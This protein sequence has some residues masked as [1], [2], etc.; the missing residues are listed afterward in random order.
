VGIPPCSTWLLRLF[1]AYCDR[2]AARHF[3]SIR[4]SLSG[5]LPGP[6]DLPWVFYSNHPSWWDPVMAILFRSLMFPQRRLFA[7]MD[8]AALEKYKFF[9]KLG[10]FGVDQNKLSGAAAFLRT[11][12]A[13][14]Q[15]HD[16]MLWLTPQGR[17]ADPRER[18][19]AFRGGL[20]GL[21]ARVEETLFVPLA[22]EYVFWE[23]RHPEILVRFGRATR[24]GSI[25]HSAIEWNEILAEAL[26]QS[27]DQLA[28]EAQRRDP[29]SFKTVF[30]GRKGIGGLYDLWR[31]LKSM[32]RGHTF[33]AAH[34]NRG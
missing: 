10:F 20:G 5:T 26:E 18:P 19:V 15:H 23:E 16:S 21:A 14:L 22:I 4:I 30:S 13:I 1:T 33:T 12:K 25:R 27:Q 6:Q 3:N 28:I 7:P 32:F 8:A 29:G 17:F 34:G 9:K 24:T 31:Q 11:S 2:Y